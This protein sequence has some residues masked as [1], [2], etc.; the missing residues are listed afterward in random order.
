MI[1]V[2]GFGG[3]YPGIPKACHCF[4]LNGNILNPEIAGIQKI[5]EI[6]Q[7]SLMK[8]QLSGPTN[9][10]SIIKYAAD[11]ASAHVNNGM[12]YIIYIYIYI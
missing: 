11:M 8:I 10:A 6:Y 3:V 5:Q 1:P 7:Q 12:K 9:F 2:L 4:A